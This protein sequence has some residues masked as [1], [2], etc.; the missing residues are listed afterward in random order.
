MY[1]L[2]MMAEVLCPSGEESLGDVKQLET[3]LREGGTS[4]EGLSQKGLETYTF[5]TVE[6]TNQKYKK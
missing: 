4:L 6:R 2:K 1:W 5:P 3:V